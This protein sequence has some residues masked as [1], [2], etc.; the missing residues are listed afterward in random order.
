M[1]GLQLLMYIAYAFFFVGTAYR[2]YRMAKMPVHLRWDL[3]PI[4][5]EK[6]KG[7]YGGSYFEEIDWWTKPAEVS[8]RS[9]LKEMARE[10]IFI[11]SMYH[12]NRPLWFFSFPFHF[13]LYLITG[14]TACRDAGSRGWQHSVEAPFLR[15]RAAWHD[16]LG[17]GGFRGFGPLGKPCGEPGTE[18]DIGANGLL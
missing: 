1:N 18:G 4:P 15:H 11:Q 3:Y 2:A 6:D 8:I 10:I 12:N 17:A 7:H 9:E 13:G 14:A 16:R 5:H